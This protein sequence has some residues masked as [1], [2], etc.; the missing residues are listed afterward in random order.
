MG[1]DEEAGL[2]SRAD[3]GGD[4]II[5]LAHSHIVDDGGPFRRTRSFQHRH[6]H[7]FCWC[8][9]LQCACML[10]I[11]SRST[12]RHLSFLFFFFVNLSE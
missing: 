5:L 10:P 11:P 7:F 9:W 3:G 6:S 1:G 4:S 8:L 2:H 12:L